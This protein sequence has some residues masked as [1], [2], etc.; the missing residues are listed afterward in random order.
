MYY[1]V[2]LSESFHANTCFHVIICYYQKEPGVWM[3]HV[4]E[5]F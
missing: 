1:D 4:L 5:L 3:G 2:Y